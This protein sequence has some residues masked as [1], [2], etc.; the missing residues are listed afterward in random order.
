[1]TKFVYS[2]GLPGFT[3]RLKLKTKTMGYSTSA[4]TFRGK[5]WIKNI[6]LKEALERVYRVK[7][8]SNTSQHI[9]LPKCLFGKRVK[10]ILVKDDK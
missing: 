9:T 5:K 2:F 1:M 6:T 3:L 8:Y 7:S 4:E 10:L